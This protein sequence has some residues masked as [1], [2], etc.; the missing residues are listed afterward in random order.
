MLLSAG[1]VTSHST[2]VFCSVLATIM[3][4]CL[5]QKLQSIPGSD[6]SVHCSSS[7]YTPFSKCCPSLH[8]APSYYV[9]DSLRGICTLGPICCGRHDMW[10]HHRSLPS[11][12]CPDISQFIYLP[13]IHSMEG[14]G[15]PQCFLFPLSIFCLLLPEALFHQFLLGGHL[16]DV[17]RMFLVL[18]WIVTLV[19][20]NPRPTCIC[21]NLMEL[22][23]RWKPSSIVRSFVTSVA[24][25]SFCSQL[26]VP[27]GSLVAG[28]EYMLMPQILFVSLSWLPRTCV[29]CWR[30]LWLTSLYPLPGSWSTKW[31]IF[32]IIIYLQDFHQYQ[33]CCW[34]Y[35]YTVYT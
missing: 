22:E 18:L 10:C 1:K 35:L 34:K 31:M 21:S 19:L 32:F 26:T 13:M 12:F 8:I 30:W 11:S 7:L 33:Y 16:L 6:D 3:S 5:A 2:A 23:F 15:L 24:P 14:F 9:L 28:R 25:I 27:S 17:T 4:G 29:T 20:T